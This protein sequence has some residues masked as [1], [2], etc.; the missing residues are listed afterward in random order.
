MSEEKG[1]I[2]INA[3]VTLI[4]EIKG[5]GEKSIALLKVRGQGHKERTSQV[6]LFT[7]YICR[8]KNN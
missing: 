8:C 2:L 4:K 5:H 6:A 3:G 7:T 1:C